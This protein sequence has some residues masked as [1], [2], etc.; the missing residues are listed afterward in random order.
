MNNIFII[1][2][3]LNEV[4]VKQRLLLI[5][6]VVQ[7]AILSLIILIF[8][9]III[10][11]G[12]I[13]GE[14]DYG[15]IRFFYNLSIILLFV[16]ICVY[17][18]IF[19]SRVLNQLYVSNTLE[20]LLSIKITLS[21]VIYAIY[22]RGVFTLLVILV[23][24]F[25]IISVAFYF[26]GFGLFRIIRL[27]I[28]AIVSA[29]LSSSIC[30]Y[31]SSIIFDANA[32]IVVSYIF[33]IALSVAYILGLNIFIDNALSIFVY[34]LIGAILSLVMVSITRRTKIFNT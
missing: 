5:S 8:A 3:R 29:V 9:N 18:P 23:S 7:N 20:H 16:I 31:I 11:N 25:P 4:Y 32:S 6:L 28:Y 26:G 12:R 22:L 10:T 14:L 1:L 34:V 17:T 33:C 27:L 24:S 15:Q 2:K 19:F 30:L 13:N 21:E